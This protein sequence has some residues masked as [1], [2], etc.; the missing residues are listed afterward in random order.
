MNITALYMTSHVTPRE[1]T[2]PTSRCKPG[3]LTRSHRFLT[4]CTI[5]FGA[6]LVAG[7]LLGIGTVVGASEYDQTIE[8]D[9]Q[10]TAGGKLI[11]QADRGSLEL[12]SDDRE[13]IQVRVLRRVKG[14]SRAQADEL[15]ANQEVTFKQDGNAL[16]IIGRSKKDRIRQPTMEVRYEIRLPKKFD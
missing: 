9:F 8:K 13:K 6:G 3:P 4:L 15:F 16:S 2:R 5:L 7:L 12:K 10:V 11:V 14:G 1:G